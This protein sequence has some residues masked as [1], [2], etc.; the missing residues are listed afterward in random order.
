MRT[1]H[2][3]ITAA[4]NH[5]EK[6]PE[7][8]EYFSGKVPK[9]DGCGCALA[10]IGHFYGLEPNTNYFRVEAILG[11]DDPVLDIS[12]R[13]FQTKQVVKWLRSKAEA[14]KTLEHGEDYTIIR[15]FILDRKE[16]IDQLPRVSKIPH[17]MACVGLPYETFREILDSE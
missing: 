5:I 17:A 4:A 3:A 9:T 10:W 8:Y 12:T 2:E 13:C 7:A 6:H 16:S 11:L 14:L 1:I 15:E